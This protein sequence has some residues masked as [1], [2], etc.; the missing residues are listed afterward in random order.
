MAATAGK[1]PVVLR[2][3]PGQLAAAV[4][5]A[6]PARGVFPLFLEQPPPGL[7]EARLRVSVAPGGAGGWAELR[8]HLPPATPPGTY[9]GTMALGE[10]EQPVR[11]EVDTRRHA[12]LVPRRL[13]L[14]GA[15]G[16]ELSFDLGVWN[17][18]N[19][20]L[21][22][23]ERAAFG[24]YDEDGADAVID[25]VLLAGAEAAGERALAERVL[26]R[27]VPAH[28]A[29]AEVRLE[30]RTRTLAPGEAGEAAGRLRVPQSFRTGASYVGIWPLLGR[31]YKVALAVQAAPEARAQA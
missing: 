15:P 18:G 1:E 27:L 28:A 8:A 22:L 13:A 30:T 6:E 31:K 12:R 11:L 25:R 3:H 19:V 16:A 14:A 5:L 17:A 23:P 7:G 20:A 21:T 9:R 10:R 24:L 26:G 4:R 2:G 29:L